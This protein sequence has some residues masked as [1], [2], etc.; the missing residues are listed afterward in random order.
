M[1]WDDTNNTIS[2]GA[3]MFVDR[4]LQLQAERDA[5]LGATTQVRAVLNDALDAYVEDHDALP[6]REVER[7]LQELARAQDK[8]EER[9]VGYDNHAH[10]RRV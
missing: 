3:R 10:P 4:F 9:R 6:L 8:A 2:A 7:V 1:T 5:L